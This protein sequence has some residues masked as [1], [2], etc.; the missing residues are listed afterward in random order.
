[1]LW[2]KYDTAL[3]E[4][5][6]NSIVAFAPK[7]ANFSGSM[8]LSSRVSFAIGV[9]SRGRERFITEILSSMGVQISPAFASYLRQQDNLKKVKSKNNQEPKVKSMRSENSVKR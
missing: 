1:M 4:S 5:L 8:S 3:N 2:H 7:T 9:H 6:N